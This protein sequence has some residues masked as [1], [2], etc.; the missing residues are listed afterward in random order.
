M[1]EYRG[2][3]LQRCGDQNRLLLA[4]AMTGRSSRGP[5]LVSAL[6]F[7]RKSGVRMVIFRKLCEKVVF[8][9]GCV[10][11]YRSNRQNSVLL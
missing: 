5:L 2:A 10:F 11:S 6:R 7:L 9:V 3:N 4:T 1:A 8:R